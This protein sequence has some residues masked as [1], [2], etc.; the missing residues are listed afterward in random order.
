MYRLAHI[1][2]AVQDIDRS[3]RFYCEVLGCTV[4]DHKKMPDLEIITLDLG[5]HA[6]ELLH[7]CPD[8]VQERKT[9]HYDHIALS[10]ED[11]DAEMNRLTTSGIVFTA[12]FPRKTSWGQR[13]AFFTGLDGERIELVED[14]EQTN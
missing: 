5:G 12:D 2:I 13:I 1:G 7:Y 3:K 14:G 6:L 4:T 10:V 11:L 9:G 8:P